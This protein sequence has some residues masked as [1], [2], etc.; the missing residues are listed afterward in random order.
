M[1]A[2]NSIHPEFRRALKKIRK[3]FEKMFVE[4]FALYILLTYR[5]DVNTSIYICEDKKTFIKECWT[6]IEKEESKK[7]ATSISAFLERYI[8]L[9]CIILEK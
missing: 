3:H 2:D 7:L 5:I 1:K 6:K 8:Y 4:D 9:V